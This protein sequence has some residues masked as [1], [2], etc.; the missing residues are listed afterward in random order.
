MFVDY[1]EAALLSPRIYDQETIESQQYVVVVVT[2][3]DMWCCCVALRCS[4]SSCMIAV[5]LSP[6]YLL[7]TARCYVSSN[8]TAVVSAILRDCE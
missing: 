4:Y 8:Q 3:T 6:P 1:D 7:T 5:H 2:I